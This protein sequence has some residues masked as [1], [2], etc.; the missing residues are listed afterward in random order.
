MLIVVKTNPKYVSDPQISRAIRGNTT[1]W[2]K[3]NVATSVN[4]T[5]G[6]NSDGVRRM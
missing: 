2:L 4:T 5:N 3:P 1:L 6:T